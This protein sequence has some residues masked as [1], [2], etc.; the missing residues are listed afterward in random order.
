MLRRYEQS[1][2]M[3]TKAVARDDEELRWCK[4]AGEDAGLLRRM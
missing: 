1:P 3:E 4:V 2:A